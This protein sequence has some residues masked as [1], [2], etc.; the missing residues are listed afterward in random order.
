MTERSR[1]LRLVVLGVGLGLVAFMSLVWFGQ[2][3]GPGDS[4]V[5]LAAGERLNA[6]HDLYALT[7]GDRWVWIKP[8][9]W[10]VPLLSPPPIA[11]IWRPLALL[12]PVVSVTLWWAAAIVS[13]LAA[14]AVLVRRAPTA[15]GAALLVVALPFVFLMGSANF[16]AFRLGATILAWWLVLRR[17][18]V[19]AGAVVGV[20]TAIKLTPITLI[21]W[22][23]VI[24]RW[25]GVAAAGLAAA[26]TF[27]VSVLGAG[28]DAHLAYLDV[29]RDTYDVGTAEMSLAGVGRLLGLDPSIAR[30]L[31]TLAA[32]ALA[33]GVV[34][35]RHHAG[36]A[37]AFAV[38]A[39]VIGTP[40]TGLHTFGVLLA[41]V[42]PL[43]FR[44][45]KRA[46]E[47]ATTGQ[48]RAAAVANTAAP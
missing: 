12:P 35:A 37:F 47:P 2:A 34:V 18:D 46:S 5:Y 44:E 32:L 20:M 16:D 21:G 14:L 17:R 26:A 31:P 15:T 39:S 41:V 6:G 42:A 24:G 7:E 3:W 23:F 1:L 43:A 27:A 33:I 13:C 8:P 28:W 48:A 4:L 30:W 45:P 22:L 38:A 40:A 19:A 29:I 36:L 9:Y 10:T 11:V 25:R